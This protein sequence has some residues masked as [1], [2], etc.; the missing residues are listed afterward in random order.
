[1]NNLKFRRQFLFTP[2]KCEQLNE[3]QITEI[4]KYTLYVHPDCQITIKK[5]QFYEIGLV[6]YVIDPSNPEKNNAAI[7]DDLSLSRSI[8]EMGEKLYPYGGRFVLIIKT[9]DDYTIFHDACGLKSV[10]YT[11]F[12]NEAYVASQ[13]LLFKLQIPLTKG[14]RFESYYKS[15]YVKYE[16]EHWIPCGTSLYDDVFQLVPNH[17]FNISSFKQVRFWPNKAV[18]SITLDEAVQKVSSILNKSLVAANQRFKLALALTAGWD[19][20]TVLSA[21][22]PIVKD[23]YIYTLQYRDLTFSSFDIKIPRDIVSTIGHDHHVIDCRKELNLNF[24][25]LYLGNTD[26]PHLYDWGFIANGMIGGYPS[27]RI[28]IKGNCAE[29]GRCF[30]YKDGKQKPVKSANDILDLVADWK[31]IKF[32]KE[33]ITDWFTGIKASEINKSYSLLDLFYWEHRMGSWQSQSQLEWDI[34]QETFTPFNN[35]E[36]LE[37]MLSVDVIYRKGPEYKLFKSVIHNLW[38][39]TLQSPINPKTNTEQVLNVV[40]SVLKEVGLF[41]AIKENVNK[42][43]RRSFARI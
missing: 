26:N 22:K 41:A 37:T 32:V 23:L 29:I 11:K 6:G 7:L 33:Q 42:F 18:T 19:S 43:K 12:E 36:L 10:Y 9:K 2:K 15:T 21:C 35:R 39:E 27:E 31:K 14:D 4:G 25:E 28:A 16:V 17:Y 1:M 20:R 3:W 30:F 38:K 24:K 8:K 40:K 5:S 34:I 13:P